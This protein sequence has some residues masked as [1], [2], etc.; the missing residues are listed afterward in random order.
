MNL[1]PGNQPVMSRHCRGVLTDESG[2]WSS[3]NLNHGDARWDYRRQIFWSLKRGQPTSATFKFLCA[4]AAPKEFDFHIRLNL[5]QGE[6]FMY[7]S[8]LTEEY[9]E[10]NKG[11]VGDPASL[12]G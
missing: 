7:A 10:F 8:D 6:A 4:A 9:V 2:R 3:G 12:G 5:G 11:D 1:S